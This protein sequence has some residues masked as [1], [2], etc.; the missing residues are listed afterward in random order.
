MDIT[1][2]LQSHVINYRDIFSFLCTIF[3]KICRFRKLS[4]LKKVKKIARSSIDNN[5]GILLIHYDRHKLVYKSANY[6]TA[7][8]TAFIVRTLNAFL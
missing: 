5:F 1:T 6:A 7:L 2:K 4:F 8:S 3:L